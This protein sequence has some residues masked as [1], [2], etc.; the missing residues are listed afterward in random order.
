MGVITF[1]LHPTE[2]VH[3]REYNLQQTRQLEQ[4]EANRRNGRCDN[5]VQLGDDALLRHDFDTLTVA[6]HSLKSLILKLKSELRCEANTAHHTKRVVREG[7]IWLTRGAD[8]AIIEVIEATKRVDKLTKPIAIET[9]GK[10]I[11]REVTAALVIFQRTWLDLR[12]ARL[13]RVAL[14][15]CAN[16]LHLSISPVEHSSAVSF[17][18]S[19]LST[20]LTAKL[21]GNSHTATN[22]HNVDICR[23]T[24]KVVVTDIAAD[25]IGFDT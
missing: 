14:T 10:S 21:L 16:K 23:G 8:D 5:L 3:F 20:K 9:P 11:Y 24:M 22:N 15:A 1:S 17:V 7:L 25:D 6:L 12:V 4:L 13:W 19:N 18:D 2:G